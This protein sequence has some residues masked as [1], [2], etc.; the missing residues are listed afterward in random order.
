MWVWRGWDM[1]LIHAHI[2][3]NQNNFL[4]YVHLVIHLYA[5]GFS[6]EFYA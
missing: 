4:V 5:C 1:K 2:S 6:A 3:L